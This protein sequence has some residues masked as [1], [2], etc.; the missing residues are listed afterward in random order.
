M[1]KLHLA[2]SQPEPEPPDWRGK[3]AHMPHCDQRVLHAPGECDHCDE[4]PELQD[5]REMW[6][7]NYTGHRDEDKLMCPAEMHRVLGTIN[8]WPGN[9]AKS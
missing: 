5:A 3:R 6:G 7:I 9:Q 4:Y 8:Q 1:R 2:W